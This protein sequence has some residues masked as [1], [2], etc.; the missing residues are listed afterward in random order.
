MSTHRKRSAFTLI[1]LLVVIAI[2]AILIGLLLPAVQKVREAAARMSCQNNL[3]QLGLAV[4]GYQDSQGRLPY[5]NSPNSYG[6]DDNGRSWS[7]ISRI[8]PHVEQDNLF[9]QLNIN[10]GN[11]GAS[12]TFN[13]AGQSQATQIKSLLCP[14]DSS[15]QAPRTDRANGSTGYGTGC[16]NYKGVAGD[17]WCWGNVT[18]TGYTGDCNGLDNGNG[19]FFRSDDRRRLRLEQITDGT[20]NTFMVGEDVPDRNVHLGW[21]RANYSTG[22]CAIPLNQSLPGKTP[23]FGAGDWPNV[24]SFRSRHAGGANFCLADGSVRM[25]TESI[26]LTTYRALSTA[27]G[28]EVIGNY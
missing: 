4:H 10:D 18:N 5:S 7:W 8:L 22:T 28:G 24:Y 25:V 3:K 6:Y 26:N 16:T 27:G 15:S 13:Q 17:N 1:E 19:I 23:S 14:S 21:P 20:S 9:K 12:Y 2:I 11:P